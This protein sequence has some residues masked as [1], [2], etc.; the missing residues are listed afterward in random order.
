MGATSLFKNIGKE[1]SEYNDFKE[2]LYHSGLDYEVVEEPVYNPSGLPVPRCKCTTNSITGLPI[3]IVG[4]NYNIIQ[5]RDVF[6]CLD[7]YFGTIKP[8]WS[9]ALDNGRLAYLQCKVNDT[10]DINGD[11]IDRYIYISNSHDGTSSVKVVFTPIRQVCDNMIAKMQRMQTVVN[12]RHT[13]NSDVKL[14]HMTSIVTEEM[15]YIARLKDYFLNLANKIVMP[16]QVSAVIMEHVLGIEG[17]NKVK[18]HGGLKNVPIDEISMMKRNVVYDM[19]NVVESGAGQDKHRGT[20]LW[21]Y[22]GIST[23]YNNNKSSS[24]LGVKLNNLL[25]NVP[26]LMSNVDMLLNKYC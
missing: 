13:K 24:Q 25:T 12:I 17:T 6:R 2:M 10:V 23:Y 9:G 8:V 15:M 16:K 19:Y 14:L 5:N 3:G 1:V 7:G 26:K 22:N 11:A 20:A 18:Q 4:T 21:L